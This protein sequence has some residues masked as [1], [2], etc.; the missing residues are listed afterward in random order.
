MDGVYHAAVTNIGVRPTIG[1]KTPR[2]ETC[3]LGFSGDLYGRKVKVELISYLRPE[4]K[5]DSL[6]AL[7]EA[8]RKDSHRAS[9]IFGNSIANREKTL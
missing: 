9:E 3:I 1:T 2:S 8:I 7:R 4:Q 6:E 5:F